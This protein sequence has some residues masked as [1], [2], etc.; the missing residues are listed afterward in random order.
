MRLFSLIPVSLLLVLAA[1]TSP[2]GAPTSLNGTNWDVTAINGTAPVAGARQPSMSFT[3]DTMSGTTGCNYF[4]AGYT[5]NGSSL[6]FTPGPQT[7]MAC[8]DDVMKQED[9][10]NSALTKVATFAGDDTAMQLQDAAGKT[11]FTLTKAAAAS[12][13]PLEGTTWQLESI[14]TGEVAASAV[15]GSSVTMRLSEGKLSGKACNNFNATVTIDG[16]SI[17]VGPIASTRMACLNDE[18][19]KQEHTV[20]DMLGK[21]SGFHIIGAQLEVSSTGGSLFF[22]AQ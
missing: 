17:A 5:L 9:A 2:A 4:S 15:A 21:A 16:E 10:F 19:T 14:R 12:A 22:R 7:A 3:G 11:L 18:L 8:S 13:K 6:S 20:L 1:C